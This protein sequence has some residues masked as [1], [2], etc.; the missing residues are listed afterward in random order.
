MSTSCAQF[1]FYEELN[2]F[3][4]PDRRKVSFPWTFSARPTV[5]Q[6][7]EALRV[8]HTEVDLV[9][10]NGSSV[11]FDHVLRDGD[12]VSVYPVFESLDITP[13]TRLRGEPLR[14]PAFAVDDRLGR[15]AQRLRQLGVDAICEEAQG[16]P[17]IA[18]AIRAKGRILLTCDRR[19]LGRDAVRRGYWV[20]SRRP[21][22]Q[23]REV[24]ARFDLQPDST[25]LLRAY[26]S[27]YGAEPA[28]ARDAGEEGAMS[29]EKVGVVTHYFTHLHVGAVELTDGDLAVGDTIHVK[30]HTSDFTQRVDSVQVEHESVE[31]GR[32]G[33]SVGLALSEHAREHDQVF[34]VTA[35]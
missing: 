21:E 12:R 34:K 30:G 13:V 19:L 6:A 2:E 33:Q 17:G 3:L 8:P 23:V 14:R 32:K 1:R 24:L 29:E 22:E 20:R 26:T 4:P 11:G 35:E 18:E 15:L 10:V 5:K 16:D 7:V 27:R 31:A 25:R 9:L 28:T